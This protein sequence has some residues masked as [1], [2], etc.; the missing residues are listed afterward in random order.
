MG[1]FVNDFGFYGIVTEPQRG[2]EYICKLLV[3]YEVAFI[4]LRMK[5]ESIREVYRTAE[6]YR[7]IS[8]GTKSRFI[9]NDFV[10]VAVNVWAD[11]VHVGQSDMKPEDVRLKMREGTL[12]GLSTHNLEQ[13]KNGC[14]AEP[15]YIGVGPVFKTPTKEIPDR[16]IGLSGMKEMISAATVPAVAIGAVDSTNLRA[17]LQ[18]G[19]RNFAS[20]RPINGS[21]NPEK[22][23]K[24]LLSIWKEE[25][26][27]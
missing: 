14:M 2:Y 5:K 18:N 15:D 21:D 10:D 27:F 25:V 6:L 9:V 23:L 24:T 11:G 19:A 7:K 3:D 22:A 13:V 4:Q 20:V 12:V 17:V 1:L 8:D 16:V 26:L